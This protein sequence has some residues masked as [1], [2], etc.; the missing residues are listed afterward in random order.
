MIKVF[1][2]RFPSL[3]EFNLKHILL[4]LNIEKE[5]IGLPFFECLVTMLLLPTLS[6]VVAKYVTHH[7]YGK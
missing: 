3:S 7:L 4:V 2:I 5:E 1:L 6:N